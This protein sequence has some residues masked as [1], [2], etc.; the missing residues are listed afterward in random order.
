MNN[1]EV[2]QCNSLFLDPEKDRDVINALTAKLVLILG[3]FTENRKAIL[4]KLRE[5]LKKYDLVPIIFDIEFPDG[6]SM[7][8]TVSLLARMLRFVIADLSDAKIVI[9]EIQEIV[10]AN[11]SLPVQPIM[12][13]TQSEPS[14][15]RKHHDNPGYLEPI[16]YEDI[17]DLTAKQETIVRLLKK[18]RRNLV[19]ICLD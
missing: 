2:A 19:N 13:S 4:D 11:P 16:S 5:E 15:L 7:I 18:R 3:R 9:N 8:E 17:N 1:L 12:D 6:H 10:P 14:I